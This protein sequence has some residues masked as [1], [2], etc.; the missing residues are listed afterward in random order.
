MPELGFIFWNIGQAGQERGKQID[1][2]NPMRNF[3]ESSRARPYVCLR[4]I[5][6]SFRNADQ[7]RVKLHTYSDAVC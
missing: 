1:A 2:L 7:S 5:A 6:V 3:S 4:P